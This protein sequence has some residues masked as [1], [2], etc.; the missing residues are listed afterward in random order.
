MILMYSFG[1]ILYIN[2]YLLGPKYEI[3]SA[4]YLHTLITIYNY[5]YLK[6]LDRS[7]YCKHKNR[8]GW[9]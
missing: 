7:D 1:H 2:Y 8:L 9:P 5:F 3:V 4:C 6:I